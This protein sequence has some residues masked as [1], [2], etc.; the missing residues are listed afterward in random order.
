MANAVKRPYIHFLRWLMQQKALY[1]SKCLECQSRGNDHLGPTPLSG[2]VMTKSS[3]IRSEISCLLSDEAIFDHKRFGKVWELL[4]A[5]D[6][7][8]RGE[9]LT[10]I[11]TAALRG[12]A[13]WQYRVTEVVQGPLLYLLSFLETPHNVKDDA[14]QEYAQMFL[15]MCEDCLQAIATTDFYW[16]FR[17]KFRPLFE[18]VA[19][20][21]KVDPPL[22]TSLLLWRSRLCGDT[23]H[24]E[25]YISILQRITKDARNMAIS[26]L[27]YINQHKST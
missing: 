14:R 11:V 18:R 25:G 16:K 15:D 22:Y 2:F 7:V 3:V 4:P 23:Q 27:F 19:A 20:T 10:L 24:V 21:G 9:A 5:T 6:E 8:H 1:R 13:S 12:A 17:K 26:V